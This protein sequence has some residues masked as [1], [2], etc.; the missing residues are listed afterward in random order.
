MQLDSPGAELLQH[1]LDAPRHDGVVGAIASDKFLDNGPQRR[2]RQSSMGN[3]HGHSLPRGADR[4]PVIK[5]LPVERL[6]G[7]SEKARK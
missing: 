3:L 1:Q 6:T 4:L 2:G 5:V 7:S